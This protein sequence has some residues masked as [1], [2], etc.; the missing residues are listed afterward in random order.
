MIV[1]GEINKKNT[2]LRGRYVFC[3]RAMV[4]IDT[5]K[6]EKRTFRSFESNKKNQ[7]LSIIYGS[8]NRLLNFVIPRN[9]ANS[10]N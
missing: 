9:S 3:V 8:V 2:N 5:R 1:C 6:N 4:L 7:Y 10:K